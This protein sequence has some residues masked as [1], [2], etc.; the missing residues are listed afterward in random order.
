MITVEGTPLAQGRTLRTEMTVAQ[1][2]ASSEVETQRSN[3]VLRQL[4]RTGYVVHKRPPQQLKV[5][6]SGHTSK[7]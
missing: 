1:S 4:P 6:R 5:A 2:R 3:D 7:N